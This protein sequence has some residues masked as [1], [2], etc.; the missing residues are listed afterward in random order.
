[1]LCAHE[2]GDPIQHIPNA[3]GQILQGDRFLNE[4]N[5]EVDAPMMHDR[6]PRIAGHEQNG[7][8]ASRLS[9]A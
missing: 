7:S 2:S 1:M 5:V 9:A 8:G 4:L 6:V 3:S